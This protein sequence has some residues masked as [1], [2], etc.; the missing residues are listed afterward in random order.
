ME[1]RKIKKKNLKPDVPGTGWIKPF[2]K[3]KICLQCDTFIGTPQLISNKI[4][5]CPN[6]GSDLTDVTLIGLTALEGGFK[7]MTY[8]N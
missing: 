2:D 3:I 1:M 7:I 5:K 8:P 6:C 4:D